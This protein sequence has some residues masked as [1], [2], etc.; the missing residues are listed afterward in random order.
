M[1]PGLRRVSRCSMN[2]SMVKPKALCQGRHFEI[3]Q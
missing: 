2:Q 3:G 1:V